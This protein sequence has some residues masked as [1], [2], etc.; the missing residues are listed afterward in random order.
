MSDITSQNNLTT[1]QYDLFK[2]L[3]AEL[4]KAYEDNEKY[5]LEIEEWTEAHDNVQF[6]WLDVK[7]ELETVKKELET[8][9][10]GKLKRG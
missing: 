4:K 2:A 5:K 8:V 3:E 9:I 7:K 1:A 10:E 6:C